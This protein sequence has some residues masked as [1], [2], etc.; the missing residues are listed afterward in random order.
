M[1]EQRGSIQQ[2][3]GSQ[4]FTGKF[5]EGHLPLS[6][7]LEMELALV[8][9]HGRKLPWEAITLQRKF[10][11]FHLSS[12]RHILAKDPWYI[13]TLA[14]LRAM[15]VFPSICNPSRPFASCPVRFNPKTALLQPFFV[16][17]CKEKPLRLTWSKVGGE[18]RGTQLHHS[19]GHD[20]NAGIWV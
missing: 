1:H 2:Q 13:C 18:D 14:L 7:K 15:C 10:E 3:R 16:S 5:S 8:P 4:H 17:A 9:N 12:P 19:L 20:G 6:C 11:L